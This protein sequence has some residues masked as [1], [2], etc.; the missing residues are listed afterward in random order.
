MKK[1]YNKIVLIFALSAG[2]INC[3]AQNWN[4]IASMQNFNF[5]CG[6]ETFLNWN[7]SMFVIGN[8]TKVAGDTSIRCVARWDSTNWY[9]VGSAIFSGIGVYAGCVYN[10]QLYVAGEFFNVNGKS[11]LRIARWNGSIWDSVKG[12]LSYFPNPSVSAMCVYNNELYIALGYG[13]VKWNGTNYTLVSSNTKS[14]NTMLVHNGYLYLAGGGTAGEFTVSP[15]IIKFDGTNFTGVGLGFDTNPGTVIN[16][17]V[18]HNN[19][20]Y[21]GGDINM[22]GTDTIDN[23]ARWNGIKWNALKPS[24]KINSGVKGLASDGVKLYI[25]GNF[26]KVGTTT[27]NRALSWDGTNYT[28]MGSAT[29]GKIAHIYKN[30]LYT[31][32]C[33]VERWS[34]TISPS[35]INEISN[36]D[37]SINI[38][39][40]PSNGIIHLEKNN[41]APTSLEIINLL[42]QTVFQQALYSPTETIDVTNLEAGFY[43]LHLIE[44]NSISTKKIIIQK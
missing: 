42:G 27:C 37:I 12:G 16:T 20:L 22:S 26:W 41:N 43:T 35:G 9:N 31:G 3:N 38:Y 23:L 4:N 10:N 36:A 6:T 15:H 29:Y 11:A 34:G 32:G 8:F 14:I 18:V 28:V 7:N 1:L 44:K 13:L 33:A 40:N 39:P 25:T 21:V 24:Q 2:T 17:M 30:Q 5:G 19:E